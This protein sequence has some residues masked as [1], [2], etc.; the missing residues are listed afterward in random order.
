M[1]S[2]PYICWKLYEPPE[3][4][5]TYVLSSHYCRSLR[6]DDKA[7]YSCLIYVSSNRGWYCMLSINA[8][9]LCFLSCHF[10]EDLTNAKPGPQVFV[11]LSTLKKI[12]G[13]LIS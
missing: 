13:M 2:V 4:N 12:S 7:D 10:T 11:V 8:G 1:R 9:S 6:F 5:E 3:E